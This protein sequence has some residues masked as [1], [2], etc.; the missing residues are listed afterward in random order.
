MECWLVAKA[1]ADCVIPLH[2]SDDFN[3]FLT[4]SKQMRG[5]KSVIGP[6]KN[7]TKVGENFKRPV[8]CIIL[9]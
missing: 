5:E 8:W 6:C 7:T 3:E 9:E 4:L 1:L 2:K